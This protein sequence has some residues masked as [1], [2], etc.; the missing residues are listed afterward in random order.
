VLLQFEYN[1][2]HQQQPQRQ[3]PTPRVH[4]PQPQPPPAPHAPQ[5]ISQRVEGIASPESSPEL[6]PTDFQLDLEVGRCQNLPP[7][8]RLPLPPPPPSLP[9]AEPTAKALQRQESSEMN[10]FLPDLDPE[11]DPEPAA[12][13]HADDVKGYDLTGDPSPISVVNHGEDDEE[14]DDAMGSAL[15]PGSDIF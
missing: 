10:P 15:F 5:P 2:R 8:P 9:R 3:Q 4:R 1:L 7:H 11:L 12:M 14:D 13:R 6:S